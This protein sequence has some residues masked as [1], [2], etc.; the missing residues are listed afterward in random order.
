MSCVKLNKQ[1]N[2]LMAESGSA[3]AA[4]EASDVEMGEA[5]GEESALARIDDG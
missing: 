2:K 3:A 4:H 5:E 1:T